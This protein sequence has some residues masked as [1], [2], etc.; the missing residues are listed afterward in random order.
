MTNLLNRIFDI[1][2]TGY[3]SW[4]SSEDAPRTLA[5]RIFSG[6]MIYQFLLHCWLA[7]KIGKWVMRKFE[8]L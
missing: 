3:S 1:V 8:R 4:L 2:A 6:W 7:V 5:V